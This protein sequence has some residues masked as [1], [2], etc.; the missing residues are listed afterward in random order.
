MYKIAFQST[1]LIGLTT[2]IS[3]PWRYYS[4]QCL[5][6]GSHTMPQAIAD[7]GTIEADVNLTGSQII[8][9]V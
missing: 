3:I 8:A 2:D 4:F 7:L 6:Y 9:K 5:P 1:H